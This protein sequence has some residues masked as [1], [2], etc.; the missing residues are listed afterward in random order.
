MRRLLNLI[1]LRRIWVERDLDRE[2]RYHLER[3]MEDL[4]NWGLDETE[5][6]RKAAIEFGGGAGTRGGVRC[7]ILTMARRPW[8]RPIAPTKEELQ[9]ENWNHGLLVRLRPGER[10]C[11]GRQ[12]LQAILGHNRCPQNRHHRNGPGF[13]RIDQ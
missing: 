3:R 6:R 9:D 5:A 7:M 12:R 10:L 13:Q 2:L 11:T 4:R 8:S 1:G